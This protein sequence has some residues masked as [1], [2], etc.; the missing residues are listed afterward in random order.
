MEIIE[1]PPPRAR[2][3]PAW[4]VAVFDRERIERVWLSGRAD[5]RR[6]DSR[7][8]LETPFRWFSVTKLVTAMSVL[9]HVDR[10]ALDLDHPVDRYVP[11]FAP[12]PSARVTIAHLLSHRSGLADPL[13]LS[14]VHPPGGARRTPHELTR[15]TFERNRSLHSAPGSTP[16]YTNL[17]YLVLGEVLSAISGSAYDAHVH[18]VV[19][20]PA[21]IGASFAP[22]GAVGHE[23]LRSLRAAAMALAFFPRTRRL[24]EYVREG[25][26]GLTRFELE[27][28]AYGGL[29]GSL[30]DLVR[31]GRLHLNDG[32]LDGVRVI[33]AKLAR[34]MRSP[35]GPFGLG[36][37]IHDRGWIGH[38]G[39]A[40]GYRA[41]L[42]LHPERGRGIAVLA[43]AGD[44]S[45]VEVCSA[46]A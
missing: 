15:E 8:T 9:A 25:W 41:E 17:G 46:L 40:G 31:L 20:G 5:L 2:G 30:G 44:A 7:V 4:A 24:I 21:K 27:G 18:D 6:E 32:E 16:A 22:R 3:A 19:L 26:V 29:V 42:R 23:R 34:E 12:K 37:W 45:A 35:R 28:Q 13:P 14:W 11:W 38:G 33:S 1:A 10:G 43:S 36:F 39:W